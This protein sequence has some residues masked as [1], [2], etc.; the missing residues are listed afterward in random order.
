VNRPAMTKRHRDNCVSS[1]AA[2]ANKAAPKY[3]APPAGV[4][5][6]D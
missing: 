2:K 3:N 1:R 5:G 4:V 6:N